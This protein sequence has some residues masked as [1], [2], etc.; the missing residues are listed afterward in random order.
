MPDETRIVV[1]VLFPITSRPPRA[2]DLEPLV[3]LRRLADDLQ[4]EGIRLIPCLSGPSW[5]NPFLPLDMQKFEELL[6]RR[7]HD[8]S[9][10]RRLNRRHFWIGSCRRK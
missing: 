1:L 8:W 6:E 2:R 3:E 7:R 10:F 4:A 5:H 9:F